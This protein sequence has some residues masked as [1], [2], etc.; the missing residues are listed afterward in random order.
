MILAHQHAPM[1]G[2][3]GLEVYIWLVPPLI[4]TSI[5][6]LLI[7][8]G[9]DVRQIKTQPAILW[10]TWWMVDLLGHRRLCH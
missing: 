5:F 7:I 2:W 10:L 9:Q 3:T 1:L 4:R 6:L 8:A